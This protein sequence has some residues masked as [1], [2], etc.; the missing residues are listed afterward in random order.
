MGGGRGSLLLGEKLLRLCIEAFCDATGEASGVTDASGVLIPA[1]F[2]TIADSELPPAASQPWPVDSREARSSTSVNASSSGT[3]G[4]VSGGGGYRGAEAGGR[5]A[6]A[7]DDCSAP[8]DVGGGASLWCV[9]RSSDAPIEAPMRCVTFRS[10]ALSLLTHNQSC[11]VPLRV[12]ARHIRMLS[13]VEDLDAASRGRNT[14]APRIDVI[15]GRTLL[16]ECK[17]AGDKIVGE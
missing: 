14:N 2:H 3:R 1:Q 8:I 9:A 5:T 6:E 13:P 11:R 10:V 4:V 17:R 12:R 16:G 15:L 7:G